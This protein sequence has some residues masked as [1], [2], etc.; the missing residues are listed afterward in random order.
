MTKTH[1]PG[2]TVADSANRSQAVIV[3]SL[4]TGAVVETNAVAVQQLGPIAPAVE[5]FGRDR[6]HEMKLDALLESVLDDHY[7]IERRDGT[8]VVSSDSGSA[9]DRPLAM[10]ATRVAHDETDLLVV[11]GTDD[12]PST[13]PRHRLD[14]LHHVLRHTVRNELTAIEGYAAL[15]RDRLEDSDETD[16][17]LRTYATRLRDAARSLKTAGESAA[18]LAGAPVPGERSEGAVRV[19]ELV[20]SIRRR[21]ETAHP[22]VAVCVDGPDRNGEQVSR[23]AG[24]ELT[25]LLVALASISTATRPAVRIRV[26]ASETELRTRISIPDADSDAMVCDA[27]DN[28]KPLTALNHP[29]GR[30]WWAVQCLIEERGGRI[31]RSSDGDALSVRITVPL[32][33]RAN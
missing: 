2:V 32:V 28:A 7:R 27:F 21:I 19:D 17:E 24:D 16:E 14:V 22:D 5:G 33:R 23:P 11:T 18:S 25:E 26:D 31:D 8:V 10:A 13:A 12:C 9:A 3:L 6:I 20:A 1:S 30:E 15:L 4:E 29:G